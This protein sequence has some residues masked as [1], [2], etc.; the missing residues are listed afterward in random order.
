MSN[1][2]SQKK[3]IKRLEKEWARKRDE[4]AEQRM[5]DEDKD[6]EKRVEEFELLQAGLEVKLGGSKSGQTSATRK[7]VGREAGKVVVEEEASA[8]ES[9]GS[10][11]RGTKRKFE[12]DEAELVRLGRESSS[13]R[14]KT[15]TDNG[16]DDAKPAL[17][18]FWVPSET[19]TSV[20]TNTPRPSKV[21]PICPAALADQP[22]DFSLK[23]LVSV[24][25]EEEKP[26]SGSDEVVRSCPAC[27]KALSNSTKAVLAKPCGHVICKPC[28][29]KFLKPAQK[30]AH[31]ETVQE[32]E[33]RCYVCQADVT[34]RKKEKRKAKDDGGEKREKDK[35][36]PG[37]VEISSEGTGFAGGGANMVKRAG[38]AFQC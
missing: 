10:G 34:E 38:V 36:R 26:T 16:K 30:H 11:V 24:S 8:E 2:L 33:V 21:D 5:R 28:G 19:P 12:I 32:G 23:T 7:V 14:R 18:S 25:F 20:T 9:R 4:E 13:S 37:L 1:L 35:L 3:E 6:T 31:D 29:D 15:G 17:P 27:R 22:H